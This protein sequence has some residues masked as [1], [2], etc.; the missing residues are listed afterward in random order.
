V[1]NQIGVKAKLNG[2]DWKVVSSL[3]DDG[4]SNYSIRLEPAK[5]AASPSE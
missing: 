3:N 2:L 4:S 1:L 5:V